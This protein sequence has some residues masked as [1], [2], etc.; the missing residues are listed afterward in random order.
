MRALKSSDS[1]TAAPSSKENAKD[2]VKACKAQ[3]EETPGKRGSGG[4]G[5]ERRASATPA[6][7]KGATAGSAARPAKAPSPTTKAP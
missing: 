2:I 5:G 4:V 7:T 3:G 1:V 6:A